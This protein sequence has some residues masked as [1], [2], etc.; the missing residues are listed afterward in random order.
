MVKTKH[1][2]GTPMEVQQ[3]C[4]QRQRRPYKFQ[5]DPSTTDVLEDAHTPKGLHKYNVK[6]K[7]MSEWWKK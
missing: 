4:R 6:Y 7:S 5:D 1:K 3:D 2:L